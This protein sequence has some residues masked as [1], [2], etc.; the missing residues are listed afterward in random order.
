MLQV[1][2]LDV[3][4][5][6]MGPPTAIARL[7]QLLRRRRVGAKY[8]RLHMRGKRMRH[9]RSPRVVGRVGGAC[10]PGGVGPAWAH[11]GAGTGV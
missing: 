2:Y 5:V 10:G 11:L 3:A 6:T 8:P 1:F 9:E 7:L 4:H